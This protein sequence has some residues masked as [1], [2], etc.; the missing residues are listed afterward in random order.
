M[1]QNLQEVFN[2][3]FCS[4]AVL[5]SD[6]TLRIAVFVLFKINRGS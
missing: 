2:Q 4:C 3:N 1:K 5:A 6:P